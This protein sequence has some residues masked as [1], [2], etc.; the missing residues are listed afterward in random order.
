M[1]FASG[2]RPPLWTVFAALAVSTLGFT[3]LG[4]GLVRVYDNQL[5]RL[6]ETEL[7]AQGAALGSAFG[8]AIGRE[9]QPVPC[10]APTAPWPFPILDT[11]QLK[12][13]LPTLDAASKV[14]QKKESPSQPG[15]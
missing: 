6:T 12:P 9:P 3:L 15:A 13:I 10:H 5:V 1:A 11:S 4:L 8:Q 7:I 14:E 2:L